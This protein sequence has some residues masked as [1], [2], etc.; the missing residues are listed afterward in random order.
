MWQIDQRETLKQLL[1]FIENIF[2][3]D[4]KVS[5]KTSPNSTINLI[6]FMDDYYKLQELHE[7]HKS[8]IIYFHLQTRSK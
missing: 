1:F 7:D 3:D 2:M 4:S 8:Q 5:K 6:N